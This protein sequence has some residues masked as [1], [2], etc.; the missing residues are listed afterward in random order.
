MYMDQIE[1]YQNNSVLS[2]PF[3][4][5]IVDKVNSAGSEFIQ[6]IGGLPCSEVKGLLDGCR[7]RL[8]EY[9]GPLSDSVQLCVEAAIDIA[10]SKTAT[11]QLLAALIYV[12]LSGFCMTIEEACNF[13]RTLIM[14]AMSLTRRD[15][16]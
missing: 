7:L 14:C 4:T 1:H 3:G 10:C 15:L 9:N 16:L 12:N 6:W 13:T 2:L 8:R 5:D 11:P